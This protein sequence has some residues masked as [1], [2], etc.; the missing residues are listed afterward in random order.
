M[1]PIDVQAMAAIAHHRG[2]RP[3][4]RRHDKTLVAVMPE[5]TR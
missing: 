2:R 5:T 3:N 1:R 4:S